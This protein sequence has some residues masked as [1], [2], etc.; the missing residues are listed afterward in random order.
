MRNDPLGDLVGDWDL[1][2]DLPGGEGLRGRVGT[3]A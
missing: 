2:S 1:A 3:S